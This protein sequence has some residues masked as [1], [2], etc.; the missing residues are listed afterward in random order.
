[1]AYTNPFPVG[2]QPYNPYAYQQYQQ[3]QQPTQQ[4]RS[5]DVVAVG[6]E[7]AVEDF[8]V[9][10]GVTQMFVATDD[11]FVAFKSNGANGQGG[12][13]YYDK[14]PPAPQEPTFD[15]SV[16]VRRDE[17]DGIV[18]AAVAAAQPSKRPAK[19]EDAEG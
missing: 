12:I 8:F 14:R 9:P 4:T 17:I 1:M 16:Y 7:K 15:P 11:S 2:Y 3:M 13:T 5:V 19:K 18:A 10:V 6:N